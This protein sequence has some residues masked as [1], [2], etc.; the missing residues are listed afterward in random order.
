MNEDTGTYNR[1]LRNGA[2]ANRRFYEPGA[3][4]VEAPLRP[5]K[6]RKITSVLLAVVLCFALLGYLTTFL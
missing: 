2:A 6:L 5:S 1:G 4:S 3:S